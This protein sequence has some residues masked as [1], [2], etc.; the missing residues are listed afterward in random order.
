[1]AKPT[2]KKPSHSPQVVFALPPFV[3]Q[4]E[5]LNVLR[6]R[7]HLH[8]LKLELEEAQNAMTGKLDDEARIEAGPYTCGMVNLSLVIW[9]NEEWGCGQSKLKSRG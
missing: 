7:S 6:L 2:L 9:D 4:A 1:M 5:I 8:A 3:T